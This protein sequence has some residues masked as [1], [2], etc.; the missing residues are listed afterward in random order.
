MLKHT[1][2]YDNAVD[3]VPDSGVWIVICVLNGPGPTAVDAAT[4]QRYVAYGVNP[5]TF[6][7]CD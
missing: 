6:T 1:M 4:A 3:L 2:L 5:V 7:D